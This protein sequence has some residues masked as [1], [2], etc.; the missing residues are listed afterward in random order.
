MSGDMDDAGESSRVIMGTPAMALEFL[1]SRC[2]SC[3]PRAWGYFVIAGV[4][5]YPGDDPRVVMRGH[6]KQPI[7]RLVAREGID[8]S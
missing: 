6:I 4:P 8:F 1:S 7:P 5:P 3:R 2:I